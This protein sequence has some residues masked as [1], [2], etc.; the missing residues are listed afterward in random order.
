MSRYVLFSS[1][2]DEDITASVEYYHGRSPG[3]EE[4]FLAEVQGTLLFIR[5]HPGGFPRIR[6]QLRQAPLERF[7]YVIIYS[8]RQEMIEV[9]RVFNTKQHPA[10]KVGPHRRKSR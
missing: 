9:V 10:K 7:P 5:R 3:L 6:G 8:V 4:R 2:A 1:E